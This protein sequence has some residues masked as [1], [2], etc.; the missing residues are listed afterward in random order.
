M[1]QRTLYRLDRDNF[2]M[3]RNNPISM[4]KRNISVR[5]FA[6]S[7][8]EMLYHQLHHSKEDYFDLNIRLLLVIIVDEMLNM[9]N[10]VS[11]HRDQLELK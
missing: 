9:H 6:F 4:L 7:V 11:N 1:V 2:E 5:T 3:L 8:E 10:N